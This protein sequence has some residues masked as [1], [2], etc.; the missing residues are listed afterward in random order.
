MG[1]KVPNIGRVPASGGLFVVILNGIKIQACRQGGCDGCERTPPPPPT[2]RKGPPGKRHRRKKK[3]AKDESLS[4]NFSTNA[5]FHS[6]EK[7]TRGCWS[8]ITVHVIDQYLL[9]PI[10][11]PNTIMRKG[12]L[13]AV[14][15]DSV[16]LKNTLDKISPK[17]LYTYLHCDYFTH[18]IF[19]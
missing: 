15:L 8:L 12:R 7:H 9:R 2:D 14:F 4:S 16:F 13:E 19:Q 6:V 5:A 11:G 10:S 1:L 3:D 17:Y 18:S